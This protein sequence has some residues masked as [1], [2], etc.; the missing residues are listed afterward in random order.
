MVVTGNEI[1][2]GID[3]SKAT[4]DVHVLPQVR[5]WQV[6][7]DERG[8]E[9][10][11]GELRSLAPRLVVLEATGGLQTRAAAELCAAGLP[12]AVVNPRQVRDFAKST[13][14]LAKTD[15]LDAEAIARF[16]SAVRPE[17]R[18]LP[19][20][21]LQVLVDMVARRRQLVAMRATEK[22]RRGTLAPALRPRLDEH[23]E[24]LADA[25]S[26]L[27]EDIDK[28]VRASPAWRVEE[29]LLTSVPGVGPTTAATLIAELPELGRIATKKLAALVGVAPMN[30][31]S[32]TMRGRRTIFGGRAVVRTALY[33][34][35]ITAIR[36][37]GPIRELYLRLTKAGKPRK[38]AIV[39][40]MHKMLRILNAIMRT[41][42]PW[43]AN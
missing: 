41:Q 2:V 25:I 29:Q 34:A 40:C 9:T 18:P 26:E 38:V 33:M 7:Y 27:G 3:V 5:R 12:V 19:D 31:D 43:R 23:L 28:A 14:R 10:L 6:V 11:V 22:Q 39:A 4:L 36:V 13:G 20:A 15:R 30:R 42:T 17:P 35:T 16:A 32:G 8:L 37:A 1:F 21:E 24:W